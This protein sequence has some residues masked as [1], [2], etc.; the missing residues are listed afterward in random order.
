MKKEFRPC[1]CTP[2]ARQTHGSVLRSG[3]C[4]VCLLLAVSTIGVA[5][6]GGNREQLETLP[7][8]CSHRGV[9]NG[10]ANIDLRTNMVVLRQSGILCFD[11]DVSEAESGPVLAH[12]SEHLATSSGLRRYSFS[13]F[14]RSNTSGATFTIEPKGDLGRPAG[15][16]LLSSL[17]AGGDANARGSIDLILSPADLEA[18]GI[19]T[20]PAGVGVAIPLRDSDGCG[21]TELGAAGGA[22]ELPLVQVLMPSIVCFRRPDV[23]QVIS[24]WRTAQLQLSTRDAFRFSRKRRREVHVWVV[25]D[26]ETLKEVGRLGGDRVISNNPL[27]LAECR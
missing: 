26:C 2:L 19:T 15:V 8:I 23:Q 10:N 18:A 3:Y 1:I 17:L 27:L 6:I 11:L 9:S 21:L 16:H 25:D 13:E 24:E 20:L 4:A 14:L 5:L 22:D 7:I 12:P